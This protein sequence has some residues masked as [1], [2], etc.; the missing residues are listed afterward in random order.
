M[1]GSS[2]YDHGQSKIYGETTE[3]YT[4]ARA[5]GNEI[6]Y[7]IGLGNSMYSNIATQFEGDLCRSEISFEAS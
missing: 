7:L 3:C 5:G 6:K 4:F 1:A 2:A